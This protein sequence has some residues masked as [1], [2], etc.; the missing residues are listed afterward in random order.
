MFF[1]KSKMDEK[2]IKFFVQDIYFYSKIFIL[3]QTYF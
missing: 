3:I 1:A 2:N